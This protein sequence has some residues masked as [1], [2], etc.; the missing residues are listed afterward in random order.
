LFSVT[1]FLSIGWEA[2]PENLLAEMQRSADLTGH[3][4]FLVG[5]VKIALQFEVHVVVIMIIC[6]SCGDTL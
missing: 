2:R 5:C 6:A 1:N 4:F 3:N